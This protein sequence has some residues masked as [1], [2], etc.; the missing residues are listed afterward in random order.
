MVNLE[1]TH[2]TTCSRAAIIEENG[3]TTGAIC[4]WGVG[5]YFFHR[6]PNGL[7][8]A[9]KWYETALNRGQYEGDEDSGCAI[10][11]VKIA[12]LEEHFFDADAPAVSKLREKLENS[13]RGQMFTDDVKNKIRDLWL[14][15]YERLEGREIKVF[16]ASI[17]LPRKTFKPLKKTTSIIVRDISSIRRPYEVE[18][19]DE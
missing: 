14:K 17:P 12:V 3:F 18:V 11:H 7:E 16:T 5:V 2:G 10:I 15:E 8:F 4:F 19:Q 13:I 6:E 9:C 1:G